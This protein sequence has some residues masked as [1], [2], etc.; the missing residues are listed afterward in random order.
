VKSKLEIGNKVLLK[1]FNGTTV[2]DE[3]TQ[4]NENYWKLIDTTGTVVQDPNQEGIYAKFS[5]ERRV[6]VQFD[7]SVKSFNL[8]CHNN[9]ENSLW[10]NVKDLEILKDK[11]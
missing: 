5:N 10:I 6:L 4:P 2:P 1:S 7:K 11:I 9:V 8:D 3:N